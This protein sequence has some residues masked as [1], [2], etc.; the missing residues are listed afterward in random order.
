MPRSFRPTPRERPGGP[1]LGESVPTATPF[2]GGINGVRTV[3]DRSGSTPLPG[4]SPLLGGE[5]LGVLS[6]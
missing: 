4:V 3:E 2:L 1:P 5:R 6:L